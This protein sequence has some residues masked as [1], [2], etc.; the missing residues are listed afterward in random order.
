MIFK[1][2]SYFGYKFF[3]RY[4]FA[5]NFS[6]SVT[7]FSFF[8]TYFLKSIW[9]FLVCFVPLRSCVRNLY[10]PYPRCEHFLLFFFSSPRKTFT[11]LAFAFRLMI[12]F[13]EICVCGK[14]LFKDNLMKKT[15]LFLLSYPGVLVENHLTIYWLFP[16]SVFCFFAVRI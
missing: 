16:H 4:M 12:H 6:Q 13:E 11:V 3:V 10:P 7:W 5:N 14:R 9:L 8:L 2:S 1:S 15:T